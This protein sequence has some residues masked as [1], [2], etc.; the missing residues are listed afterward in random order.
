MSGKEMRS[1]RW[2]DVVFLLSGGASS[3]EESYKIADVQLS[4]FIDVLV[5]AAYDYGE[6]KESF[7]LSLMK[8]RRR[9]R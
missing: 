7:L 4:M 9:Q 3:D 6:D 5:L 8:E 2:K 1:D